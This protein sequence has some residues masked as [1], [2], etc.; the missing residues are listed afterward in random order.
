VAQPVLDKW[1]HVAGVYDGSEAIIYINGDLGS[2]KK[3]DGVLKHNG[4]RFWMGARKL[5]LRKVIDG[6]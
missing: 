6:C 2:K 3:F 4:E 5:I 1:H